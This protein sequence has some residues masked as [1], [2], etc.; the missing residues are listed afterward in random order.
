MKKKSQHQLSREPALGSTCETRK[1]YVAKSNITT[2]LIYKTGCEASCS[3][4]ELAHLILRSYEALARNALE[5]GW[6]IEEKIGFL[7]TSIRWES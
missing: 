6:H 2:L 3:C 4:I 1:C 5:K 7:L